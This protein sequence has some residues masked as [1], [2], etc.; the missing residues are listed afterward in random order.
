MKTHLS[1]AMVSFAAVVS[2]YLA[3][4]AFRFLTFMDFFSES[5][6]YNDE[7]CVRTNAVG[8]TEDQTKFNNNAVLMGLWKCSN[9]KVGEYR[10]GSIYVGSGFQN[11][12]PAKTAEEFVE[13]HLKLEKLPVTGFPEDVDFHPHGIF[14]RKEDD[15]LYVINHAY[16][17]GGERI[18]VFD[19]LTNDDDDSDPDNAVPTSL[20]YKHSITSDWMKK[21]MNGILNSLVV[22]EQNKFYVTQYLPFPEIRDGWLDMVTVL[23]LNLLKSFLF[24]S[25]NTSVSFCEYNE[26]EEESLTCRKVAGGFIGANGLTHNGDFSKIFVADH[27][28]INVF[29]RDASTN[30]LSG[31]TTVVTPHF[32]DNIKYDD[33]SGNVYGGTINHLM[34]AAKNEYPIE[35]KGAVAG[36]VELSSQEGGKGKLSWKVRQV[37]SSWKLNI[38]SNGIRMNSYYVAGAG[39]YGYDGLLVCPVIDAKAELASTEE[40]HEL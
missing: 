16:E 24:G 31:R 22:V 33:V 7:G 39:G 5:A 11:G 4:T 2:L 38:L 27:K 19:I 14:I 6:V 9:Y 8:A 13:H 32:V 20:R 29:D 21:E 26:L 1:I 40:E 23:T 37:F 10:P 30:D 17:K 35:T 18:E 12:D 28:T 34:N 25:Q 3:S 36:V 15:E